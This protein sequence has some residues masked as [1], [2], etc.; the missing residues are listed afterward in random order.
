[1]TQQNTF[2]NGAVAS[3]SRGNGHYIWVQN[4]S[5]WHSSYDPNS[6]RW[7]DTQAIAGIENPNIPTNVKL[8]SG[9]NIIQDTTTNQNVPGLVAVWQQGEGND[10]EIYYSAGYYNDT[11]QLVWSDPKLFGTVGTE[12]DSNG[13][14]I[15][16]PTYSA[17]K[18]ADLNPSAGVVTY[19]DTYTDSSGKQ[20]Q[21]TRPHILVTNLK[22]NAANGEDDTD[23]YYKALN[24]PQIAIPNTPDTQSLPVAPISMFAAESLSR[25]TLGGGGEEDESLKWK[26][27]EK[28]TIKIPLNFSSSVQ[29][30]AGN[31]QNGK[32]PVQPG[33]PDDSG[34]TP[35]F[36]D[37]EGTND[38]SQPAPAPSAQQNQS[39]K[40]AKSP[41]ELEISLDGLHNINSGEFDST[42]ES[43][44]S[45]KIESAP[46]LYG[47]K[48]IK[49]QLVENVVSNLFV[50]SK[51]KFT[52]DKTGVFTQETY[53]TT[54]G[55][56]YTLIQAKVG[57]TAEKN[58]VGAEF[59][60]KVPV[61]I[62]L[63]VTYKPTNDSVKGDVAIDPNGIYNTTFSVDPAALLDLVPFVDF[64][65]LARDSDYQRVGS[66]GI[67]FSV[68]PTVSAGI[69]LGKNCQSNC[70]W[71]FK[72]HHNIRSRSFQPQCCWQWCIQN[73]FQSSGHF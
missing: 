31:A 19:T 71:E 36:S 50:S 69:G 25:L 66:Y 49:A 5:L 32:P 72:Y 65:R 29:G 1:M 41:W 51:S 11:D 58:P 27:G 22:E 30:I 12:T 2:G 57:S 8:I 24:L 73:E 20:Q 4:G 26:V 54:F 3:D 64:G 10:S 52:Y 62:G 68:D 6:Q 16:D 53:S 70:Q 46:S 55:L 59:S 56:T 47:S 43:K 7:V 33:E 42:V 23:L 9:N 39:H 21:Q 18:F 35:L 45:Y 38:N 60:F 63:S 61:S 40:K 17:D 44:L 14:P 34:I 28:I 37:I 48:K 67:I 13:N 15:G